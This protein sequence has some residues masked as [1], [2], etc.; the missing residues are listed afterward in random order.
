MDKQ[1]KYIIIKIISYLDLSSVINF[2]ATRKKY[3]DYGWKYM[4]DN[5]ILIYNDDVKYDIVKNATKIMFSKNLNPKNL[6]L[7]TPYRFPHITHLYVAPDFD[8]PINYPNIFPNLAHLIFKGRYTNYVDKLLDTIQNPILIK[9]DGEIIENAYQLYY[10]I[11][12]YRKIKNTHLRREAYKRYLQERDP[13]RPY[14][15]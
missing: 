14:K 9:Y 13:T 3:K 10:K 12:L 15:K 8:E 11:G 1:P 4:D 6:M 5:F 2:S 7:I